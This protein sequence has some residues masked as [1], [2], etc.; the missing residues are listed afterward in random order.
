MMVDG[1]WWE[2]H[3]EADAYIPND[4]GSEDSVVDVPIV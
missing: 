1:E 2:N 4:F 3:W